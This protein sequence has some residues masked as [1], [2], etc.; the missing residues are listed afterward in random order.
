MKEEIPTG[1]DA[2]TGTVPDTTKSKKRKRLRKTKGTKRDRKRSQGH[3]D[4]PDSSDGEEF[5]VEGILNKRVKSGRAEYLIKWFGWP[6]EA[7]TWEPVK[8]LLGCKWMIQKYEENQARKLLQS[9]NVKTEI[10]MEIVGSQ[11]VIITG[12]CGGGG[13]SARGYIPISRE[14]RN[15]HLEKME[16]REA[17][18]EKNLYEGV[19]DDCPDGK[20][21][22]MIHGV[23]VVNGFLTHLVQWKSEDATADEDLSFCET[24]CNMVLAVSMNKKFPQEVIAFYERHVNLIT[25]QMPEEVDRKR[26]SEVL[27][28]AKARRE[29]TRSKVLNLMESE[30]SN[31]DDYPDDATL[32]IEREKWKLDKFNPYLSNSEMSDFEEEFY[33]ELNVEHLK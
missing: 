30:E 29:E 4:D 18:R 2:D 27:K 8:N 14:A 12:A 24:H 26:A 22:K 33:G 19:L 21:V 5:V 7:N 28:S 32:A 23:T 17:R 1:E 3:D 20:T 6:R 10:K 11:E 9:E 16:E 13:E 31:D 15:V 25:D